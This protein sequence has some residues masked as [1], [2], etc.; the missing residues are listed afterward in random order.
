M[1]HGRQ[2][3]RA[4]GNHGKRGNMNQEMDAGLDLTSKQQQ[5]LHKK[6]SLSQGL[7]ITR[8][9]RLI[10]TLST[11]SNTNNMVMNP[12]TQ[13]YLPN[14][15]VFNQFK[16]NAQDGDGK[17]DNHPVP[18]KKVGKQAIYQSAP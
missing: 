12:T 16:Q 13:A 2:N 3:N 14:G 18:I 8:K 17:N 11:S 15:K 5:V 10:N 9:K 1:P 6:N 7:V 4:G